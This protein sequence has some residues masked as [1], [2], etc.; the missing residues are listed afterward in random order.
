MA[1]LDRT[2]L[3]CLAM[4]LTCGEYRSSQKVQTWINIALSEATDVG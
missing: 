3:L 2:M 4:L 1:S